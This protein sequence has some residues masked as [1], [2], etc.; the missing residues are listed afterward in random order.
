MFSFVPIELLGV[1]LHTS[2]LF[3]LHC[4]SSTRKLTLTLTSGKQRGRFQPTKSSRSWEMLAFLE[5]ASQ[6]V[7]QQIL[8][9]SLTKQKRWNIYLHNQTF[10]VTSP[11][12]S[13]WFT[14]LLWSLRTYIGERYLLPLIHQF[15]QVHLLRTC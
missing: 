2:Q 13:R 1:Q 9:A 5:S 6:L 15:A 11:S 3:S 14:G 12:Y 7:G 10:V 8:S 4:S